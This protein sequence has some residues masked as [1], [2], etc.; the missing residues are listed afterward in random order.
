M[1][2]G[3]DG[4][5]ALIA[6]LGCGGLRVSE[7][8]ALNV[9]DVDLAHR[10]LH[11]RDA[12][13]EAGIRAVDVTPRL[14]DDLRDYLD[15]RPGAKP[16]EPAFPTQAGG[17]RDKDNI[18]QR[19]IA[20]AL[21]KANE[22]RIAAGLP[23]IGVHVTPHTLRR[24]YISLMLAAGADV[25]YVQDQV[26]HAD[27]KMTLEIYALV[28][29]RRDRTRFARA[30]DDLMSDAIPSIQRA[31]MPSTSQRRAASAEAASPAVAT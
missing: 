28:V 16:D 19:V 29:K 3:D 15:T 27:P 14:A 17:R 22:D 20:P 18:R 7:A 31:K 13:T 6:T 2:A 11:V 1:D 4:R 21:R 30:F 24:T 8:A 26:G 12:K 25:P 23:P 10:K 9:E 5:R